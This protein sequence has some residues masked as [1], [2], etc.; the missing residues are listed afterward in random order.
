MSSSAKPIDPVPPLRLLVAEN[1]AAQIGQAIDVP[2][3]ISTFNANT[4]E[5]MV[6]FLS[7]TDVFVSS[8]FSQAWATPETASLRLIQ[9]V[10]AG[11]D[12]ID[13][14][15]VPSGCTVCNVYGHGYSVAEYTFMVMTALNRDL[16]AQNAA[17]RH[18]DWGGGIF[19]NGLQGRT[20]LQIGLGHIGAEIVRWG[21]FLQMNV[22]GLTRSPST[23]RAATLGLAAIGGLEAL[24][25]FLP[26]ADFVVVAIPHTDET[27]GYI[28]RR[29]FLLMKPSAF[30][31]NVARGP[32]V[33]EAA[34]Y[35]TLR[36]RQIA[37]AAIDVWYQY[38]AALDQPAMP[39]TYPLHE[40]DN[41]IMTPHNAGT[42]DG[43]MAYRFAFIG[44]NVDRLANGEPLLNVVWP[45]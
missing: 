27:A 20:L 17:M 39:S 29:E 31:V 13:F 9:G 21:K 1:F 24:H 14:Q 8:M 34:L 10:G 42:T 11:T 35:A 16:S 30:L 37:G 28:N 3:Q 22:V 41:I 38:P 19:R 7:Q 45:K 36:D 44:D 6:R 23:E 2:H 43:T 40:L 12:G 25:D 32:V 33:E 5:E 15:A 4:D 18:G 26:Q